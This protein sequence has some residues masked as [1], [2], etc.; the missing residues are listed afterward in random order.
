MEKL[1]IED[2]RQQEE[3]GEDPKQEESPLALPLPQQ[4]VI[5]HPQDQIIGNPSSGVHWG[6][7][8]CKRHSSGQMVH[9]LALEIQHIVNSLT[10]VVMI[11]LSIRFHFNS[12]ID[13][14]C[15]GLSLSLCLNHSR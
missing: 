14:T 10:G 1:K 5:N 6:G 9:F 8:S 15:N 2:R 11:H 4:F 12:L 7:S 13:T 3:I